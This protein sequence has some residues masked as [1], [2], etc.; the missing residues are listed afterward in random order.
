MRQKRRALLKLLRVLVAAL[1]IAGMIGG[2]VP[3]AHAGAALRAT[4]V[5]PEPAS[6]VSL[7]AV[8]GEDQRRD[9]PDNLAYLAGR[10]GML[11]ELQAQT[12]C[13]AFCVAPNTIATAAHCLFQPREGRMPDLSAIT[14][15]LDHK[16]LL[17]SSGIEGRR[18]GSAK[19]NISVGTTEFSTEPPL[20]APQDWA[21]AKLEHPICRFGVIPVIGLSTADLIEAAR[22]RLIFQLSYHWDY[23]HWRLAYSSRC[24][25]DRSFNGLDWRDIGQHFTDAE[26]LVLHDCDTGWASS[27][28]PI[29]M[30]TSAGPVAVAVNV[31]TYTPTRLV[32]LQG[33]VVRRLRTDVVANTAVNAITFAGIVQSL[34]QGVMVQSP[35]EISEMQRHLKAQGL[36]S[37]E[38]DGVF[39]RAT[40]AAIRAHEKLSHAP[41][42]GLPSR[43]L[44]SQLR[45][46]HADPDARTSSARTGTAR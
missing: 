9:V 2:A 17:L 22:R 6:V 33:S 41:L 37:G 42:T 21:L 3:G 20:S 28:S 19:H 30:D 24:T 14:F 38:V 15:R 40:R 39:G 16:G 31:G 46:A 18:S 35:A 29:L 23:K 8:F 10:I 27:G 45:R 36:Y 12:L 7:A 32:L 13:T 4:S 26:S 5:M 44:L 11:Y 34:A 25:I 43:A 1:P